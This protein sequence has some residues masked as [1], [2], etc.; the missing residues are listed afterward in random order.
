MVKLHVI[1]ADTRDVGKQLV[2]VPASLSGATAIEY[3]GRDVPAQVDSRLGGNEIAIDEMMRG[4]LVV[5]LGKEYDF[6]VH[7][8]DEPEAREARTCRFAG[9]QTFT[10]RE[11]GGRSCVSCHGGD[12]ACPEHPSHPLHARH[13]EKLVE[14]S[15]EVKK[16]PID[17]ATRIE[18]RVWGDLNIL[19]EDEGRMGVFEKELRNEIRGLRKFLEETRLLKNVDCELAF[20]T[21]GEFEWKSRRK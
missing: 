13:L 5:Q 9:E 16:S 3:R 4:Y 20:D 6:V 21:E 14:R 11:V 2:R 19:P 18:I 15:R 12:V 8:T 7:A 17:G 1:R 10:S